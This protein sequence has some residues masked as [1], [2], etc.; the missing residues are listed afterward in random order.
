METYKRGL[1]LAFSRSQ[2]G[3]ADIVTGASAKSAENRLWTADVFRIL[4]LGA[5]IPAGA[6][7]IYSLIETIKLVVVGW[8]ELKSSETVLGGEASAVG[9]RRLRL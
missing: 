8:G 7:C 2:P 3:D 5:P 4:P 1:A 6:R 9:F